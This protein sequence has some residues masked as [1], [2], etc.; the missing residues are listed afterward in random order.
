MKKEESEKALVDTVLDKIESLLDYN[1]LDLPKDYSV[2]NAVR[3][4]WLVLL[5]QVDKAKKPVM[6]S[7][8][9]GSIYNCL[10]RMV[11]DGLSVAKHQCAFIPRAGKLVYQVE[12][13]GKTAIAKRKGVAD[14]QGYVVYKGD[15]FNYAV[16]TNGTMYLT[17]PHASN[18]ENIAPDK[19]L[20]AYAIV[21][22]VDAT[23]PPKM[24][25][26]SYPQIRQAWS[27]GGNLSSAH[28]NFPDQMAIKT[29]KARALRPIINASDDGDVLHENR[30]QVL[31]LVAE[32]VAPPIA[33]PPKKLEGIPMQPQAEAEPV[34]PAKQTIIA[35][36]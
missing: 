32:P 18:I 16:A 24:E 9:Q 33:Q 22:F 3:A 27:M 4:A 11:T 12:Y 23:L 36:F 34:E 17:E 19:I 29:V 28:T 10:F 25:V 7:C 1:Q 6:E 21:T 8:T 26:M 14:I 31:E 2:P 30:K 35:P 20:G 13:A 5:D 15:V